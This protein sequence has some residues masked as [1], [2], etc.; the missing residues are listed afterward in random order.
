MRLGVL[1]VGSNTV[2]LLVVDA[3]HGAHPWPAHSEKVVLRLAEQIGPDG[4]LTEAG[5]DGLVK[6]VGMARAAAAGL[7]ADD[8]L[9]FATSAVRDAT[10]AAE[11][12]ARVREETGVRL[13]VLAGAD[14]ARMTFLAVRRWFGWS[15][16]RLLALDIGGG[17]LELAAGIDE[18][19]DV[20]IS[21]PLGAG[22]LSRERLRVDPSG[23]LAP[24]AEAVEELRE[25]VDE[26]LDPVVEK[27]AA[28]GWERPV[29]TSKTFR[30]LARLAGAAPSGA[31]LWARRSLT[32]TGL[33]QVLGF[34]RHIPPAQLP[35][36]EG[37][38]AARA[39]Q[40]LAGAVVA[41]AVMR[42]L[43]VD[44]LDVCPWALREGVILRR[45]DQLAPM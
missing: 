36:L 20:A 12:L 28:V 17:S 25:Y 6:A 41:E 15:A 37:V 1:D 19:P 45:L 16:G 32:R 31:G 2:H 3:H 9:A 18:E 26:R 42:R 30:T 33:R 4:A 43:D 24:P 35:E 40:L 7:D 44:A 11:V 27:L 10:N 34:V 14:E 38:S 29:A 39:H 13:E 23:T 22:R 8:L 5:A 21:L